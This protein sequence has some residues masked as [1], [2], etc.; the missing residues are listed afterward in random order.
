MN[1]KEISN[2]LCELLVKQ[3]TGETSL[4]IIDCHNFFVVKGYT[5]SNDV[6]DLKDTISDFEKKHELSKINIIDVIFYGTKK[7]TESSDIP[8][9]FSVS[10]EVHSN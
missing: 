9:Y 6:L 4:Q 5:T 2:N 10:S 3:F 7:D 1:R 8:S